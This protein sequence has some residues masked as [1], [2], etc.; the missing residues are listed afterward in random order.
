M[1]KRK[2][3]SFS[4]RLF[5]IT[6]TV[7]LAFVLEPVLAF[8]ETPPILPI[9]DEQQLTGFV[10]I[11]LNADTGELTASIAESNASGTTTYTW[12]GVGVT[13]SE[14]HILAA[15][16]DYLG[17]VVTVSVSDSN[18]VGSK[19]AT[20]TVYKVTLCK[21]GAIGTDN[22]EMANT[23][24][25]VSD[26]ISIPYTLDSTGTISNKLTY[27]GVTYSPNEINTAYGTDV[28]DASSLYTIAAADDHVSDKSANG[29]IILTA[30][31]THHSSQSKH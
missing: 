19:T 9:S 13:D 2:H 26:S 29:V 24:G 25:R 1:T 3:L 14:T 18:H 15:D 16:D 11:V 31:F 28:A 12:S 10:T 6:L 22:V 8:N 5:S 30:T 21:S 27:S 20:I 17:Q 4:K 7:A 23:Y